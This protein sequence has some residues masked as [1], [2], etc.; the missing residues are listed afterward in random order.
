MFEAFD[1]GQGGFQP[2]AEDIFARF[3]RDEF[4]TVPAKRKDRVGGFTSGVFERQ[5]R[6]VVL[7]GLEARKFVLGRGMGHHRARRLGRGGRIEAR[8]GVEQGDRSPG[9]G[10]GYL[11]GQRGADAEEFLRIARIGAAEG[12]VALGRDV[13]SQYRAGLRHDDAA[14]CFVGPLQGY[15]WVLRR[16]AAAYEEGERQK[17]EFH[18]FEFFNR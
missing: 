17:S 18:G 11:V 12:H 15:V 4:D 2:L 7:V 14:G 10:P 3:A 1:L 9:N 6:H 13:D 16:G 5:H 8:L